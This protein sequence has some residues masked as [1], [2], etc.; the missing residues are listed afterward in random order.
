MVPTERAD[1]YRADQGTLNHY[2][3]VLLRIRQDA[4]TATKSAKPSIRG[5]WYVVMPTPC[6][7]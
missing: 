1:I 6:D 5:T 2:A 7:N 4:N 3:L